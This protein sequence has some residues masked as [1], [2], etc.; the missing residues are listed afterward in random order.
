ME[1]ETHGNTLKYFKL[2]RGVTTCAP[3]ELFFN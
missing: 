2:T 3:L 1:L